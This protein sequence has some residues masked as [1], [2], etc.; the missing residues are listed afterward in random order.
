MGRWRACCTPLRWRWFVVVEAITNLRF[1]EPERAKV[2]GTRCTGMLVLGL[3]RVLGRLQGFVVDPSAH[4]L[5][6]LVVRTL[7]RAEPSRLVPMTAARL[8][9]AVPAILLLDDEVLDQRLPFE[10]ESFPA[11]V[12]AATPLPEDTDLRVT[13]LG[14]EREAETRRDMRVVSR[15]AISPR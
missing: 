6:Y 14:L 11:M 12:D 3:T 4:R 13:V 10:P 15:T 2:A 9:L 7:G 5:R 1:L 8:D